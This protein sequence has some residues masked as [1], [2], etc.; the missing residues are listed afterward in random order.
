MFLESK[1]VRQ[2]RVKGEYENLRKGN[3]NI[4]EFEVEWERLMVEL[5][6][7]GLGK[8]AVQYFI[9][10]VSKVGPHLGKLCRTERRERPDGVR[11]CEAGR[12]RVRRG[13]AV[14][15]RVRRRGAVRGSAGQCE[16]VRV[17]A[18]G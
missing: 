7:V 17:F 5:E 3:L 15:G 10:Y 8:N 2:L 1:T 14:R 11:Q 13:E 6:E 12:G 4:F 18:G 16:A 9:D